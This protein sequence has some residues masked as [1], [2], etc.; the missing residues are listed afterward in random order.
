MDTIKVEKD[1]SGRGDANS[2]TSADSKL[3]LQ[4]DR[5]F[6]EEKGEVD[7]FRLFNKIESI[8]SAHREQ[9]IAHNVKRARKK[10]MKEFMPTEEHESLLESSSRTV[11]VSGLPKYVNEAQLRQMFH[12]LSVGMKMSEW[13]NGAYMEGRYGAMLDAQ[14]QGEGILSQAITRVKIIRGAIGSMEENECI[15]YAFVEFETAA[16]AKAVI[17]K[18]A[19]CGGVRPLPKATNDPDTMEKDVMAKITWGSTATRAPLDLYQ[20]YIANTPHGWDE[21]KVLHRLRELLNRQKIDSTLD[22]SI[23]VSVDLMRDPVSND[24][25]GFGFLRIKNEQLHQFWKVYESA[26]TTA[27]WVWKPEDVVK[28]AVTE[29]EGKDEEKKDEEKKVGEKT[30]GKRSKRRREI[31]D[32]LNHLEK[33]REKLA[34]KGNSIFLK[35]SYQ[36]PST[37]RIHG[38]V[39]TAE[40]IANTT[41]FMAN[42]TPAILEHELKEILIPFGP[43]VSFRMARMKNLAF[44]TYAYAMSA[45]AALTHL[46]G[47]EMKGQR[48]HLSYGYSRFAVPKHI[49][50]ELAVD[51]YAS[52][53]DD[54]FGIWK[55]NS[56]IPANEGDSMESFNQRIK[57]FTFKDNIDDDEVDQD[58]EDHEVEEEQKSDQKS[59]KRRALENLVNML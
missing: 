24:R 15:G 8:K 6:D 18:A 7:A 36:R 56:M 23:L 9:Q 46:N 22:G 38:D 50:E 26:E 49:R 48:L 19:V 51:H 4:I 54:A 31:T 2:G 34:M 28:E 58:K 41:L 42:I 12:E 13:I 44:V 1:K 16:H 37:S 30:E 14:E 21:F 53:D 5:W 43:I 55:K 47:V 40:A 11:N 17:D 39:G 52:K 3:D 57:E 45:L 25:M 59:A 33:V 27:S 10:E 35:K 20:I 29:G 32:R